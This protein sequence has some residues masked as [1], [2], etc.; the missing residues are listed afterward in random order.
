MTNILTSFLVLSICSIC[1]YS[2]AI[3]SRADIVA[4]LIPISHNPSK[5]NPGIVPRDDIAGSSIVSPL[6]RQNPVI[7]PDVVP[8]AASLSPTSSHSNA[9]LGGSTVTV[10]RITRIGL[11]AAAP[12]ACDFA[13][14]ATVYVTRTQ[15]KAQ[16]KRD[17]QTVTQTIWQTQTVTTTS[18]TTETYFAT[19]VS[20]TVQSPY[21]AY[22]IPTS[23]P[24]PQSNDP[25]CSTSPGAITDAQGCSMNIE[26][27]N[28]VAN[29]SYSMNLLCW[30]AN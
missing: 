16:E 21:I 1:A 14:A 15:L 22:G 3:P 11:M 6:P 5:V 13:P 8:Q 28:V 29:V 24:V 4:Q 20:V 9:N 30:S 23:S 25:P 17:V 19:T 2:N 18:Y 10:A 27:R 7:G 26:Q 12:G